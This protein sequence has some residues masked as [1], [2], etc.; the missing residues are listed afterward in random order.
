MA[1]EHITRQKEQTMQPSA[2]EIQK[3]LLHTLDFLEHHGVIVSGFVLQE[4]TYK[5]IAQEVASSTTLANKR[6][7]FIAIQGTDRTVLVMPEVLIEDMNL[8]ETMA[9]KDTNEQQITH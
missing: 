2:E 1:Q 6:R 7:L 3:A 5:T 9:K 4:R 8:Y